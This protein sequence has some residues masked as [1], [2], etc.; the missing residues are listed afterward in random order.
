MAA[1]IDPPPSVTLPVKGTGDVFPVHRIYCVGRNYAAHTIEMGHDPDK[2]PPFFFQKNP[3]NLLVGQDFPYPP[4]S[5]DVHFE[6]ELAVALKSGGTD[7]S[8]DDA[9]VP[10][11]RLRLRAGHDKARF[12]GRGKKGRP[13]LGGRQ[14]I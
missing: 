1:V 8:I 11:V 7:I 12:A 13:A 3:D 10:R 6:F 9:L 2:E 4:A 5:S 14:G